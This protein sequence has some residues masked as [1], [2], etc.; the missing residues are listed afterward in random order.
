MTRG[1][2]VHEKAEDFTDEF[3][4]IVGNDLPYSTVAA[5]NLLLY[6]GHGSLCGVSS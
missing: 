4:H 1:T 5:V 3:R 6:D 2:S